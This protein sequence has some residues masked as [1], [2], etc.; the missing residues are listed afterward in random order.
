MRH[1][2][3]Y[4][5]FHWLS[6][7]TNPLPAPFIRS[8]LNPLTSHFGLPSSLVRP[9]NK[10][11]RSGSIMVV[12]LLDHW[13]LRRTGRI[14]LLILG[15]VFLLSFV[16]ESFV[17]GFRI[18]NPFHPLLMRTSWSYYSFYYVGA[19]AYEEQIIIIITS[20]RPRFDA[21]LFLLLYFNFSLSF[22]SKIHS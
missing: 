10:K 21:G 18:A 4:T 5:L 11:V 6:T 20:L 7:H 14:S 1:N 8:W 15:S 2:S 12:V 13:L 16:S 17:S 22:A 9:K 19:I 3:S